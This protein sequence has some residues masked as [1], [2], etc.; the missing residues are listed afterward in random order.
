MDDLAAGYEDCW[1]CAGVGY[2]ECDCPRCMTPEGQA[3]GVMG[4]VL[5]D[6]TVCGG[7]GVLPVDDDDEEWAA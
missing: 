4:H 2:F 7:E 6:C 5:T 1:A 3:Y